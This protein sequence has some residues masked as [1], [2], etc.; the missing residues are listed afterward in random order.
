MNHSF[1]VSIATEHGVNSAILI[2]NLRFWIAKNAANK[3]HFHDSRTWTYNSAKAFAELFPYMSEDNIQRTLKKLE[4]RGVVL[5]GNYNL[6]PYDRT[7]W[8]SLDE[9]Y[10]SANTGNTFRE[11]AESSIGTD[12]NTNN[13][14]P[15]ALFEDFWQYYPKKVNRLNVV[16]WFNTKKLSD[17]KYMEIISGLKRYIKCDKVV[18]G[19]IKDPLAWL[20]EER[21]QDEYVTTNK[22]VAVSDIERKKRIL[23]SA[24]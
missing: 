19:Y 14:K 11:N 24:I 2:E 10:L 13:T 9:S 6:N 20:R 8:Y 4:D 15:S 23:G 7:K 18:N 21:W 3:K 5:S 17:D 22:N 16:K 1:D 12:V